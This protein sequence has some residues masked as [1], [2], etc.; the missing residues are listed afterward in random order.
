MTYED[1]SRG[2]LNI[3]V[4]TASHFS[5]R[6]YSRSTFVTLACVYMRM[7]AIVLRWPT[8]IRI[9]VMGVPPF[10]LLCYSPS[11]SCLVGKPM[12]G[13]EREH[14]VC[15]ALSRKKNNR[16]RD[17]DRRVLNVQLREFP[18]W[19]LPAAACADHHWMGVVSLV[20]L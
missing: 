6:K 5:V 7:L 19:R 11:C 2:N 1:C 13:S 8:C 17:Y 18:Y 4:A 12:G 16:N 10:L 9:V 14:F 15:R 20:G 3:S